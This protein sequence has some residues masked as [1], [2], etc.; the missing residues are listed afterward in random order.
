[1]SET[2][3]KLT[4]YSLAGTKAIDDPTDWSPK[5][6]EEQKIVTDFIHKKLSKITTDKISVKGPLRGEARARA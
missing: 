5:E 2:D 6:I 4:T 1:M 3:T